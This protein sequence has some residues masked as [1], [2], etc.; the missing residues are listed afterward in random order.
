MKIKFV[1]EPM[2]KGL[3]SLVF[4]DLVF[5]NQDLDSDYKNEIRNRLIRE[6]ELA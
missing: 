2:P 1:E 3:D 6:L 5:I 4:P